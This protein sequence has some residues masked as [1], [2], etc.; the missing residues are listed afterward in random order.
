MY[1][2]K[3]FMRNNMKNIP[4]SYLTLLS[5]Q[6]NSAISDG[7]IESY[8]FEDIYNAIDNKNLEKI[9]TNEVADFGILSTIQKDELEWLYQQLAYEAKKFSDAGNERAKLGLDNKKHG[10]SLLLGMILEII[11]SHYN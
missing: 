8:S 7:Y 6:I 2:N 10:L 1:V 4:I 9:V 11:Q 3:H 5:R